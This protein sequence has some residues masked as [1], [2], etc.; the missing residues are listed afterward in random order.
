LIASPLTLA[1]GLDE[2]LI[3]VMLAGVFEYVEEAQIDL[4]DRLLDDDVQ[5]R[6]GGLDRVI[7]TQ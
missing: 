4:D 1:A 7:G 6:L 2:R 3:G 5:Q